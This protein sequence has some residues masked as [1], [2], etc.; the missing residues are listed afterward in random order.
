MA[1]VAVRSIRTTVATV[2]KKEEIW[3]WLWWSRNDRLSKASYTSYRCCYLACLGWA[4]DK[5]KMRFTGGGADKGGSPNSGSQSCDWARAKVLK[6]PI[7]LGQ[8][9]HAK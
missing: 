8:N 1:S 4:R 3:N 5:I 6:V 7:S 9:P 2:V